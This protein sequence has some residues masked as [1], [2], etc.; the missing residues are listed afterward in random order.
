MG[1]GL[2]GEMYTQAL[3]ESGYKYSHLS[4]AKS[5]GAKIPYDVRT[6]AP[7]SVHQALAPMSKGEDDKVGQGRI[8][9]W[10][11]FV[12]KKDLTR[13]MTKSLIEKYTVPS[14]HITDEEINSLRGST[15]RVSVGKR[16]DRQARLFYEMYCSQLRISQALLAQYE[17][18]AELAKMLHDEKKQEELPF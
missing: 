7:F 10:L 4:N 9:E 14:H 15:N 6:T 1:S 18:V 13:R 12:D 11:D 5:V 16:R 17:V 2:W 3:D 8:R